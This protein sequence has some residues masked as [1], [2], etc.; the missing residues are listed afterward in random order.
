MAV[1]P[2]AIRRSTTDRGARHQAQRAALHGTSESQRAQLEATR[3][4]AGS[5]KRV[6]Q[7]VH[8]EATGK[9]FVAHW[10]HRT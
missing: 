4:D 10:G 2:S 5:T 9:S 3:Y 8:V 1:R 6:L 7:R